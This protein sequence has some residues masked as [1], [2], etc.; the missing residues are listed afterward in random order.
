MLSKCIREALYTQRDA[1]TK[2]HPDTNIPCTSLRLGLVP[3][4]S[5]KKGP[6]SSCCIPDS[7]RWFRSLP[8]LKIEKLF[9]LFKILLHFF[10]GDTLIHW[11]TP[12]RRKNLHPRPNELS[13]NITAPQIKWSAKWLLRQAWFASE[14]A[15]H[16][17]TTF[18]IAGRDAPSPQFLRFARTRHW[19]THLQR[20]LCAGRQNCHFLPTLI[21]CHLRRAFQHSMAFSFSPSS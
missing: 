11:Y 9:C 5:E 12:W 16:E 18:H 20:S 19:W 8:Q 1:R 3:R 13:E 6:L 2:R 7:G 10:G 15:W 4:S 14:F 17:K 21:L